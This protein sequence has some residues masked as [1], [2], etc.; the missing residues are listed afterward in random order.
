M[1]TETVFTNARIVLEDRGVDGTLVIRDGEI[2]EISIEQC[3]KGVAGCPHSVALE[4]MLVDL[5]V[6]AL[7]P[8]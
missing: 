4:K 7:P 2:A 1:S 6:R 3:L 5:P 8:L